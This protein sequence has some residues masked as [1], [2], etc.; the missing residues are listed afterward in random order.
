MPSGDAQRAWF[1]EMLTQLRIFWGDELNW[2]RVV[3]FCEEMTALRSSIWGYRGIRGPMLKCRNCGRQQVLT[4][5]PISP[6][7]LL[8]AV[9]KI[10]LITEGELKQ[11]NKE[12]KKFRTAENL[13]S[14]GHSNPDGHE[15]VKKPATCGHSRNQTS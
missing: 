10:D 5:P 13:D 15:Q 1:P 11:L 7:S 6:R 4:L 14:Y 3:V 2:Y 8:F 9:K 12:W